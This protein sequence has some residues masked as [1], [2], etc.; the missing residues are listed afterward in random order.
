MVTT[1]V[2]ALA[3]AALSWSFGHDV[4]WLYRRRDARDKVTVTLPSRAL[5]LVWTTLATALLLTAMLAPQRLSTISAWT[6][7]RVPIEGLLA[8]AVLLVLRG[9]ARRV[10]AGAFGALLGLVLLVKG[11]DMGFGEELDR[12]FDPVFDW[13]LLRPAAEF[14]ASSAGKPVAI[15]AVIGAIAA[16]LAV[17][18]LMTAAAL[19]VSRAAGTHRTA[20]VRV[21][22]ALSVVWT[23][24]AAT[25]V[26]VGAD[27]PVAAIDAA[28]EVHDKVATV[29]SDV[30]D[31]GPFR[32]SIG[33]DAFRGVPADKM[34]TGLRGKDVLLTF[35]ESYGKVALADPG[36]DKVLADGTKRLQAA[37]FQART[38]MLTSATFGGTSWL[39]HSTLQSGL[40]VDN[41]QRYSQLLTTDRLT[42]AS[43]FRSAGWRT[44]SD[45]PA[46]TRDWSD[47]KFYGY[48]QT[49]DSRNVGY[50]GPSFSYA[51]MP[52]QYT[53]EALQRNELARTQRPPVMAEVDLVTSHNPWTPLP[54]MVDWT[55]VGDGSV[56]NP[57]PAQG[58]TKDEVWSDPTRVKGAYAQSIQYSLDTLVSYVE[59][60]G[61]D[62][63]VLVFLG[64][65]QPGPAV[66]GEGASR[67][68][69][70]TIVARDPAVLD[71]IA[72]WHWAPGLRPAPNGPVWRM[73]AFR[74]Q[75]LTAFGPR[76]QPTP[77]AAN[78]RPGS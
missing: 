19:R 34:L 56:Y 66:S 75:F 54:R 51:T 15:M 58:P 63:T 59:T 8:L 33:V 43:A 13:V 68:V 32:D 41:S 76:D 35:V 55:A 73:D 50:R 18:V 24:A 25:G 64:D 6:A 36:V 77:M 61:T 53:M 70:I 2:T 20:T 28:A 60:Y 42:L 40:W 22:V 39:A 17:V 46:N 3:L 12:P 78:H 48:E 49:Y 5:P 29:V 10:A 71:R 72:G 57:M 4:R 11:L 27:Q 65:H 62:D 52:D 38:G 21:L 16:A 47:G 14:L 1:V 37:G 23:A 7:L 69:P 45:I 44:V 67:D 26:Q 74:D 31:L 9:R 30:R